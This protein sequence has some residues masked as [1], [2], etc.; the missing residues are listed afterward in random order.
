MV[1]PIAKFEFNTLWKT[2]IGWSCYLVLSLVLGY[3]YMGYI[4]Q[5]LE[6]FQNKH[7][8][9]NAVFAQLFGDAAVLCLLIIPVIASR[10]LVFDSPYAPL[11]LLICS[12]VSFLSITLGKFL[13]S[14]LFAC[15]AII[16]AAGMSV[17]LAPGTELDFF[18]ILANCVGLM[19]VICVLIAISMFFSALFNHT[20]A[21]ALT[22]YGIVILLWVLDTTI[23]FR[24][25]GSGIISFLALMPHFEAPSKGILSVRDLGYFA[26]TTITLLFA[27]NEILKVRHTRYA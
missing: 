25:P 20:L 13:G 21:A 17:S 24:D 19:G 9:S 14:L 8:L 2:N 16:L 7:S 26:V 3:L 27:T 11:T 1:L 18:R 15:P 23:H 6:H 10:A 22:T 4:D 12:P 5:Y